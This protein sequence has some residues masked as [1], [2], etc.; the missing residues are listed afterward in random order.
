MPILVVV[1][2]IAAAWA[3]VGLRMLQSGNKPFV[4]KDTE[5]TAK[6]TVSGLPKAVDDVQQLRAGGNTAE[7]EK[8]I[9]EAL[10]SPTAT[11]TEKYQLYIQ[12]GNLL[13][14][15]NDYAGAAAIYTKAEALDKTYEITV[16][17]GDTWRQA[18]DK[19]KAKDYY[20]KAIPLI[21]QSSPFRDDEKSSLEQKIK[22]LG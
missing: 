14:D 20:Q 5:A 10:S 13:T 1:V 7:A 6:R 11:D 8:K 16:L 17:L 12:Q 9:N 19:A 18:G 4:A 15:K 2:L 3:G 22:A 21:P